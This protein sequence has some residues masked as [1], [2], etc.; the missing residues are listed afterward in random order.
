MKRKCERCG[1]ASTGDESAF[2]HIEQE[3]DYND[4]RWY[5]LDCVWKILRD[6]GAIL[7][8]VEHLDENGEPSG[9]VTIH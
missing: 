5:C 8:S 3:P 2:A 7:V 1:R 6:N 4:Y 9:L